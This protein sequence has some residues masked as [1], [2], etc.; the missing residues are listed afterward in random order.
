MEGS[1]PLGRAGRP[2]GAW[3]R[4]SGDSM[5]GGLSSPRRAVPGSASRSVTQVVARLVAQAPVGL[6]GLMSGG[7]DWCG[8]QCGDRCGTGPVV[9]GAWPQEKVSVGARPAGSTSIPGAEMPDLHPVPPACYPAPT[10]SGRDGHPLWGQRGE[11]RKPGRALSDPPP[12]QERGRAA[13]TRGRD[14]GR[15]PGPTCCC[16]ALRQVVRVSP[17]SPAQAVGPEG[18]SGC[19][20]L[21][22]DTRAAGSCCTFVAQTGRFLDKLRV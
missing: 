21:Y 1:G 8:D 10:A 17:G 16:L 4:E 13:G 3:P 15:D 7:G 11:H 18:P 6:C 9:Q 12:Q 20:K 14:W 2:L 22:K 5:P 19:S